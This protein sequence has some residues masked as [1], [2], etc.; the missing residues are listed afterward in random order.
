MKEFVSQQTVVYNKYIC[1]SGIL[2]LCSVPDKNA[3][4]E[5]HGMTGLENPASVFVVGCHH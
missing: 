1:P 5:L 3:V 4:E 2:L